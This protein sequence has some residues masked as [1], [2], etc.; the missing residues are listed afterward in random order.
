MKEEKKHGEEQSSS[1]SGQELSKMEE[2]HR[3]ANPG[4]GIQGLSTNNKKL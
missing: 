4:N 3:R 2:D 1:N